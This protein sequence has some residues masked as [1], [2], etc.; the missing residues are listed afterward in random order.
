MSDEF[1]GADIH[2][3]HGL[4]PLLTWLLD[5]VFKTDLGVQQIHGALRSLDPRSVGR[6]YGGGNG[7]RHGRASSSQWYLIVY[8]PRTNEQSTTCSR[9]AV[10]FIATASLRV[11]DGNLNREQT[12]AAPFGFVLLL[13]DV[14]FTRALEATSG[15][16]TSYHDTGASTDDIIIAREGRITVGRVVRIQQVTWENKGRNDQQRANKQ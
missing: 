2:V 14:A 16:G 10:R 7:N 9:R 1:T 12:S 5:T 4:I 8:C 11:D 15:R 6:L 13:S 3:A